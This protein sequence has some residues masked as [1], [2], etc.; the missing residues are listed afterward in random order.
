MTIDAV[1]DLRDKRGPI[2][3]W[4]RRS[5]GHAILGFTLAFVVFQ[6]IA[7]WLP[8]F[9]LGE[10]SNLVTSRDLAEFFGTVAMLGALA[11]GV[12]YYSRNLAARPWKRSWLNWSIFALAVKVPIAANHFLDRK[13]GMWVMTIV[14]SAPLTGG[15]FATLTHL[16]TTSDDPSRAG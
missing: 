9:V 11:G 16:V 3:R 2:H 15:F 6:P 12:W 5:P 7:Y 1:G 14:I 10:P 13:W 8:N 4:L